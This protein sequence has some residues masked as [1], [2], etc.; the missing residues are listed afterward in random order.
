MTG[1]LAAAGFVALAGLHV[2]VGR[3]ATY[4]NFCSWPW[5]T[6]APTVSGITH[7]AALSTAFCCGAVGRLR[8]GCSVPC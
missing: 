3:L 8:S 7:L 4:E 6:V 1:R 2:A 5:L